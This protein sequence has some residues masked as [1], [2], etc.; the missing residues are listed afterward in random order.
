MS[1]CNCKYVSM[2][3]CS[4][5]CICAMICRVTVG[6][7]RKGHVMYCRGMLFVCLYEGRVGYFSSYRSQAI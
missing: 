3:A 4:Y 2:Y 5:D 1:V 7:V 6:K